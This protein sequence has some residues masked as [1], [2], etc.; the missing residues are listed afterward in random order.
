MTDIA[1]HRA[2]QLRNSITPGEFVER[3]GSS[4]FLGF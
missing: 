1:K 4:I 3:N 2:A